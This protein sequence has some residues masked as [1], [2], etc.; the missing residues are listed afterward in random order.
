MAQ[1]EDAPLGTLHKVIGI[2]TGTPLPVVGSTGLP[3]TQQSYSAGQ[4]VQVATSGVAFCQFD[5]QVQSGDTVAMSPNNYGFCSG[6]P[7]LR[8]QTPGQILGIALAG[9]GE[10]DLGILG[11]IPVLLS[12]AGGVY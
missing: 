8:G 12:G 5:N 4:T 3:P 10:A 2:V 11:L 7:G 1:V 9:N 6:V